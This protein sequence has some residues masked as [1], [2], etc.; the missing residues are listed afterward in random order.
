M[1]PLVL[2]TS[3]CSS[4]CLERSS[5][6]PTQRTLSRMRLVASTKRE[7]VSV[8]S[9]LLTPVDRVRTDYIDVL[10][11]LRESGSPL[12]QSYLYVLCLMNGFVLWHAGMQTL[13]QSG[14]VSY[15]IVYYGWMEVASMITS[16]F[17]CINYDCINCYWMSYFLSMPSPFPKV[18]SVMVSSTPTPCTWSR[19]EYLYPVSKCIR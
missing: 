18:S 6:A 7:Q 2:S 14:L 12:S 19:I 10:S 16:R 15:A 4:R 11:F 1:K 8:P 17:V 3:L 9:L 5:L 13:S